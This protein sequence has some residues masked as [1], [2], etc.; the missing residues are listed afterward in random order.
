MPL[1]IWL[2]RPHAQ[3]RLALEFLLLLF[4]HQH[5][6]HRNKGLLAVIYDGDL[7]VLW[8]ECLNRRPAHLSETEREYLHDPVRDSPA[9]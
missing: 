5:I 8:Y 9:A 2:A 7:V 6:V 3:C 4:Y 1:L